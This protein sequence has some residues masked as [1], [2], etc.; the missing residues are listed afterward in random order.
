MEQNFCAERT[1]RESDRFLGVGS[2]SVFSGLGP[3][4]RSAHSRVFG[5]R[6]SPHLQG[7][8]NRFDT[9]SSV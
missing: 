1:V 2:A 5:R 9:P 7:L 4:K 8:T 3:G 6:T